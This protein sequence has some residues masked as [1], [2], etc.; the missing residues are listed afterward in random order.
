MKTILS[1]IIA[2]FFSLSGFS[3]ELKSTKSLA[4]ALLRATETDKPVLLIINT[5]RMADPSYLPPNSKV[6]FKSALDENDVI[7]KIDQAFT[8]YKTTIVDTSIRSIIHLGNIKRFPAYIF[9]RPNKEIFFS[10]FGNSTDKKKY[11]SMVDK[12]LSAYKEKSISELEKEVEADGSNNNNLI[13]KLIDFRKKIGITNNADL[14]EKYVN[15][16]KISDF[17]SYE[18]IRYI[19]ESGPYADGKAYKLIYNNKK[20]V[21]SFYKNEPLQKRVAVNN[22]IISNTMMAAAKEKK[23]SRAMAGANFARSSWTRDYRAGE[24]AFNN[25][26]LWYYNS[27]KDTANYMRTAMYFYDNYYM[28]VSADSIKKIE[29]R[30]HNAAMPS[31]FP[32]KTVKMVSKEKMDSLMKF[33]TTK[34]VTTQSI[35]TVTSSS[36]N[37]AMELNNA[38]WKFYEIGTKNI[39]NLT[40]AMLWSR[41]SIELNPL[42]GYYDT[43]A[44]ILYRM[45]YYEEAV[46]TQETAIEKGKQEKTSVANFQ[47]EL[48]KMKAKSL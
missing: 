3:Q 47:S 44:H 45:G 33:S 41:R 16:L 42:S 7:A 40:K 30:N 20:L 5:P 2:L 37:Y 26:I 12:A 43:L 18:N 38:A 14:I 35:V 11:L 4:V 8:V 17:D 32:N 29:A 27:V 31:P 23:V 25:Q 9:L 39:N 28:N 13:K 24:K 19:L 34:S 46:K 15:N 21:D 36:S 6:S 48:K 10:D 1:L 22:A